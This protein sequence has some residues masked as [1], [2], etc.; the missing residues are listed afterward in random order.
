M[1]SLN[2][3]SYPD[4]ANI[5]VVQELNQIIS[6]LETQ[7]PANPQSPKNQR[8]AK[9]LERELVKYFNSIERAF[10]YS[11]LAGIYNQYA[12]KE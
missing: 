10:P 11:K 7:I 12:E 5:A 1:R 2:M 4:S 8:L 3:D 9:G 6:L